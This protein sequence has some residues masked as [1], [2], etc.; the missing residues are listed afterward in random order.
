MRRAL[1]YIFVSVLLLSG[2]LVNDLPYPLVVPNVTSMVVEGAEKVEIDYAKKLITVHVPETTDLRK[3]V[4][5]SVELDHELAK[6]SIEL[7]APMTSPL[8]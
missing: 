3:V 2:C 8:P 4:V 6:A 5:Q 1:A 7:S